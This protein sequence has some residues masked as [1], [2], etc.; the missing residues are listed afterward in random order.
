VR[1]QP[2]VA[3][4]DRIALAA[5]VLRAHHVPQAKAHVVAAVGEAADAAHHQRVGAGL[6][7]RCDV[8]PAALVERA[9]RACIDGAELA[10][11]LEVGLHDG[12]DFLRRLGVAAE[13]RHRDR[14]LR[15]ANARDLDPELG[16]G[17]QRRG[18]E[19][20]DQVAPAPGCWCH[21]RA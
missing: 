16:P 4:G 14:Q 5:Q 11:A 7:P 12:T 15:Q 9:A 20:S 21:H 1:R 18:A 10:A 8:Q 17:G 13:R 19:Q 6:A 2:Q 3:G